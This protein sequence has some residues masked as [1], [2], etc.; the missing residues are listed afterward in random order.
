[1]SKPKHNPRR[2]PK[3]SVMH[4][5]TLGIFGLAFLAGVG[6]ALGYAPAAR[7]QAEAELQRQAIIRANDEAGALAERL[8]LARERLAGQR[9]ASVLAPASDLELIDLVSRGLVESGLSLQDA[10]AG[11]AELR[12]DLVRRPVEVRAVARFPDVLAWLEDVRTSKPPLA[13]EGLSLMVQP[14]DDSLLLVQASLSAF[15]PQAAQQ[16]VAGASTGVDAQGPP[17]PTR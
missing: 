17:P 8:R 12:G 11:Q 10:T 4:I 3:L 9:D 7:A 2:A 1:M 15:S 13:V 6:Y 14:A 5:H 16:S